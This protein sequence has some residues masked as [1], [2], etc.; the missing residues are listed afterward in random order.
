[1][2]E[3]ISAIVEFAPI[4][5]IIWWWPDRRE[6]G[7]SL[8]CLGAAFV[9]SG[10]CSYVGAKYFGLMVFGKISTAMGE[11]A[12]GGSVFLITTGGILFLLHYVLR[13][14][15]PFVRRLYTRTRKRLTKYSG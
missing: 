14:A 15:T 4:A 3:F 1:M 5:L 13:L 9:A 8:N 2:K 10:A 6:K 12:V 11:R 7:I